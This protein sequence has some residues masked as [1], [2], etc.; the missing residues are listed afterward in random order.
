MFLRI[1]SIFC[2]ATPVLSRSTLRFASVTTKVSDG[3][4]LHPYWTWKE[5]SVPADDLERQLSLFDRDVFRH[6]PP[7][8]FYF[9]QVS[10]IAKIIEK[11]TGVCFHSL[12]FRDVFVYGELCLVACAA[13]EGK[14][15]EDLNDL[16]I[17][18]HG[19]V[20]IWLSRRLH[21]AQPFDCLDRSKVLVIDVDKIQASSLHYARIGRFIK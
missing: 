9:T 8:H 12:A 14:F 15:P 13:R 3:N 19:A 6:D 17:V 21:D 1:K 10:D 20:F 4:T 5:T 2:R 7:Y 16:V 11:Y 18:R